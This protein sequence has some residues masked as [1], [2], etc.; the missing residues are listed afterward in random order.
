MDYAKQLI[1]YGKYLKQQGKLYHEYGKALKAFYDLD[2]VAQANG[3][4]PPPPTGIESP[5]KP[6]PNP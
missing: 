4:A 1:E 3:T 5:I 2:A 6:P